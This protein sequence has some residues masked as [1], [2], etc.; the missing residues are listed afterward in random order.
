MFANLKNSRIV[1]VEND[2]VAGGFSYFLKQC[3]CIVNFSKSV[4]LIAHNIQK[5]GKARTNNL[6][7]F[8]R[9]S[10]VQFQNCNVGVQLAADIDLIEQ[11][12]CHT[13]GKIATSAIRED[14]QSD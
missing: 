4:Q 5:Q 1:A 8:N 14:F 7:E 9:P 13:S 10:L 3:G 2:S 12:R 6:H 11:R